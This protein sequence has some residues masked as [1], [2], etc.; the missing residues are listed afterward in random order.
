M[1]R[2][3]PQG[4]RPHHLA[5]LGVVL[6]FVGLALHGVAG[7]GVIVLIVADIWWAVDRLPRRNGSGSGTSGAA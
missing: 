3:L 5:A 2:F 7:D 4:V 1:D 6:I